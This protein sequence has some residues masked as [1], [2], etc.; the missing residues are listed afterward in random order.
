[1][2]TPRM[3]GIIFEVH[4]GNGFVRF[5]VTPDKVGHKLGEF[6][7]TRKFVKH[8]GQKVPSKVKR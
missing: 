3:L 4:K 5:Q 7:P 8:P 2:A 6:A 1:M